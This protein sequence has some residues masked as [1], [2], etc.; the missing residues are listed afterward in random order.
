MVLRTTGERI[1]AI[2]NSLFL[3]AFSVT[4]LFPFVNLL[5]VSLTHGAS[6][7][8]SN[9]L[10]WPHPFTT[11]SYEAI[12]TDRDLYWGYYNTIVRT[13]AGTVATLVVLL[14]AA[15]PLSK[16]YLP[17]RN[18]YTSIFVFTLFFSARADPHPTC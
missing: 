14:C 9:V 11:K 6:G 4:I 5:A 13:V 10:L 18:L 15:Y 16:K 12:F 2:F 1:F 3:V 17:Q 8:L 7:N